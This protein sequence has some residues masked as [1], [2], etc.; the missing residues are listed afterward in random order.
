VGG[1]YVT[2]GSTFWLSTVLKIKLEENP[3]HCIKKVLWWR[4]PPKLKHLKI[5][6]NFKAFKIG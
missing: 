5:F 6:K 2:D 1:M 4:I 3:I